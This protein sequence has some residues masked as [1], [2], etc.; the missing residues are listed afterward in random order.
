MRAFSNN[1][2]V[3]H[4]DSDCLVALQDIKSVESASLALTFLNL[5]IEGS[6][7]CV[8]QEKGVETQH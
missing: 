5:A 4:R 3:I 7:A 6:H 1:T 2:V 8:D